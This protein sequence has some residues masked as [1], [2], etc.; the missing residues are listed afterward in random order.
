MKFVW[1]IHIHLGHFV[2]IWMESQ[3]RYQTY[4]HLLDSLLAGVEHVSNYFAIFS[5]RGGQMGWYI[6]YSH[7]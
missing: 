3:F 1:Y 2:Q 5:E 6:L 7:L 4:G